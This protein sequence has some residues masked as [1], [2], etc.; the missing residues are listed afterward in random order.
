MLVVFVYLVSAFLLIAFTL[1]IF[2]RTVVFAY[3]S[4]P[5]ILMLINLNI[6]LPVVFEPYANASRAIRSFRPRKKHFTTGQR[7]LFVN[8]TIPSIVRDVI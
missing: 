6:T 3:L 4:M 1:I 7:D 2:L 8:N 5:L